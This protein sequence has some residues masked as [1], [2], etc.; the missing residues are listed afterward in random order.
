M[1][2]VDITD[3]MWARAK[4]DLLDAM[5]REVL[6]GRFPCYSEI[7]PRVS[8]FPLSHRSSHL[9][10]MLDEIAVEHLSSEGCLVTAVVVRKGKYRTQPGR[11]FFA[12][13]AHIG[14]Y[15]A[16]SKQTPGDFARQQRECALEYLRGL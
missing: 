9:S 16:R 8:S 2:R 6:N 5:K 4:R 1:R 11:R 13:A 10:D 3:E 12:L 15:S 14:M 7:A